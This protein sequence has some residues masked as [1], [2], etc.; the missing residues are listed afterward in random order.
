MGKSSHVY[1]VLEV[2]PSVA[3]GARTQ[4]LIGDL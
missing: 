3:P 1:V 4:V 2:R